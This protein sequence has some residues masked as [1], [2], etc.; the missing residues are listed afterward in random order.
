MKKIN[1]ILLL[2]FLCPVFFL[3]L[4]GCGKSYTPAKCE[5]LIERARAGKAN[6]EDYSDMIDQ[7]ED[8][9]ERI[10]DKWVTLRDIAKDDPAKAVEMENKLN[11]DAEFKAMGQY[12]FNMAFILSQAQLDEANKKKLESLD[13]RNRERARQFENDLKQ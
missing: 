11:A 5:S 6:Q 10:A 8:I 2:A 7:M 13:E 4:T 3:V 12:Y 9:S 1:G